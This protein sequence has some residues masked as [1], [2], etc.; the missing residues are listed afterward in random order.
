MNT[1]ATVE[2]FTVVGTHS[3][4]AFR[5]Q[6][7]AT[8]T[9]DVRLDNEGEV[10][11]LNT[12][13][14]ARHFACFKTQASA[15]ENR[16]VRQALYKA[17]CFEVR[18]QEASVR[19][20][21]LAGIREKLGI[22]TAEDD[23]PSRGGHDVLTTAELQSVLQAV[24][25][26][27]VGFQAVFIPEIDQAIEHKCAEIGYSPEEARKISTDA[28]T[29]DFGGLKP[30]PR[31]D[32]ELEALRETKREIVGLFSMAQ[33][34]LR[35]CLVHLESLLK[36]REGILGRNVRIVQERYARISQADDL[37][38]SVMAS[39][40]RLA[41]FGRLLAAHRNVD[42]M[43]PDEV[44]AEINRYAEIAVIEACLLGRV[45]EPNDLAQIIARRA[46]EAENA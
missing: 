22:T 44:I 16:A 4:D 9:G 41:E 7:N 24:D 21:F 8:Q 40:E 14:W 5:S 46:Q 19:E 2:G 23:V 26:F 45:P 27:R 29:I 34:D 31:T 32:V 33:W 42:R 28:A 10:T 25:D 13:F 15:E 30:L 6:L 3:M 11:T 18:D 1:N 38:R 35:G 12:G 17:I 43:T 20:D 36:M 37:I 39:E